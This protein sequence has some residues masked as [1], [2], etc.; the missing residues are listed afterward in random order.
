[1]SCDGSQILRTVGAR[2]CDVCVRVCDVCVR[3]CDDCVRVC[4]GV[5]GGGGK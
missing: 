2:V 1:M 5:G 4:E 3:A